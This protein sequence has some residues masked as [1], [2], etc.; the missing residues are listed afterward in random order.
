MQQHQGRTSGNLTVFHYLREGRNAFYYSRIVDMLT[1]RD[2][3]IYAQ[4]PLTGLFSGDR[5]RAIVV[6]PMTPE[7]WDTIIKEVVSGA[8][9]DA[10][11][12]YA[13]GY[14]T[15]VIALQEALS[16][17]LLSDEFTQTS[18]LPEPGRISVPGLLP[19]VVI[20]AL[21]DAVNVC[22]LNAFLL[23][24]TF[25]LFSMPESERRKSPSRVLRI[26]LAFS[27]AL[28]LTYFA[29]G[30]GLIRLVNRFPWLRW[31]IAALGLTVGGL[32]TV[33]F[34]GVRRKHVP[35]RLAE[36]LGSI[37]ERAL[38]PYMAFLAGVLV[39]ALLLPC[40]SGPY[41]I[42]I[43]LLSEEATSAEGLI[44]LGLYNAIVT[45]PFLVITFSVQWLS[46]TKTGIR[47]WLSENQRWLRLFG[48]IVMIL[49]SLVLVTQRP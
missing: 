27:A 43:G 41:F 26:G 45:A 39:A 29:M 8:H 7:V 33:E 22:E 32:S 17:R 40:S 24:L 3:R 1:A 38:N 44:F 30:L 34:L 13:L 23:M 48:G 11:A 10:V 9:G 31:G 12:V 46:T 15:P 49:L 47:L 42:V 14:A 37:L 2:S 19:V 36:G 25:V 4:V 35:G 5:L 20:A 28:F 21:A 16:I 18:R 6:G